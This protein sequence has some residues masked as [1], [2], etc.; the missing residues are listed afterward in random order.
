MASSAKQIQ[1]M[2]EYIRR[3]LMPYLDDPNITSVGIGHKIKDGKKTDELV[4][5]FTVERR[6]EPEELESMGTRMIPRDFKIGQRTVKTD[7][8]QRT[9]RP[10]FH[11]IETTPKSG[12]KKRLDPIVP[13]IS[14]AHVKESAGTIGGIVCDA[15]TGEPYILSNWHVLHGPEGE[16]GDPVVQPGPYDD[17]S[18]VPANL[19]GRLVRSHVGLAGDCAIASID[20]RGFNQ[21]VL[22]LGVRPLRIGKA[23]LGDKVIKSGR[24]TAVTYGVVARVEVTTKLNY[25]GDVGLKNVGG[26]EIGPDPE[27]PAPGNEISKG[28]DS[29]SLWFARDPKTA[30]VTDVVLGLHF[31]GEAAHVPD[32]YALACNIHSV[33]EKLGITFADADGEEEAETPSLQVVRKGYDPDFLGFTRVDHPKLTGWG[34]ANAVLLDGSPIIPYHHF[35]LV[36]N[37]VRRMAGYTAHNI[38]GQRLKSVSRGGINWRFDNRIDRDHQVGNEAYVDNP[39]DRGHLVRR[40]A[41]VWGTLAQARR[42]N[43]DSFHYT[44]AVPQ[45]KD[46]NQ[47]EWVHLEDW[48]LDGADEDNYRLC[49]FTGPFFS[50]EDRYHRGIRI[51]RAFWKIIAMQRAAD[52]MLSVT[53]FLMNQ[54]DMLTDDQGHEYLDLQLY[55]VAVETIEGLTGLRFESLRDAQPQAVLE[56]LVVPE[57]A[58]PPPWPVVSRPEDILL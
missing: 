15:D 40:A 11:V 24:T 23:E 5:Q 32:E 31:A 47:D 10:S 22:E 26:F 25:G 28:G 33:Q 46:F 18:G 14:V 39:W 27:H 50:S 9:Y 21:E 7:V 29:G 42:A 16:I 36:M 58:E 54:Y 38:D 44:N 30:K 17:S 52:Q 1:Q 6:A 49:V 57:G 43:E 2:K 56:A 20:E 3:E 8:I 55:Q 12:R 34:L 53:A 48:V 19:L 35:S 45:H 41:V 4:V 13:G 51:P 37:K